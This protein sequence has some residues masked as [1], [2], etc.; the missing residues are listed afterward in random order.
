QSLRHRSY[1]AGVGSIQWLCDCHVDY[2]LLVV[3]PEDDV[4]TLIVVA[5]HAFHLSLYIQT[6]SSQPTCHVLGNEVV[7]HI[8][9]TGT[10]HRARENM[11]EVGVKRLMLAT[12]AYRRQV[13]VGIESQPIASCMSHNSIRHSHRRVTS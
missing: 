2:M 10:K 3:V 8:G 7:T 4:W 13:R 1:P 5:A 6:R 11:I 9:A 12:Y